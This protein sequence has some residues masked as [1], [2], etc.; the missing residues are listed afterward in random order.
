MMVQIRGAGTRF[1]QRLRERAADASKRRQAAKAQESQ[2]ASKLREDIRAARR[3][4]A[5]KEALSL[6]RQQARREVRRF[7]PEL[8][9]PATRR[10]RA[11]RGAAETRDLLD[12][13]LTGRKPPAP[14]AP[15]RRRRG[16]TQRV[17]FV[18]ASRPRGARR[19]RRREQQAGLRLEV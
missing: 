2:R 17:Q 12:E 4:A 7:G 19:P 13:A 5:R 15:R 9:Q 11:A 14:A 8:A 6:A 10:A 1:V 3:A 18:P 16:A